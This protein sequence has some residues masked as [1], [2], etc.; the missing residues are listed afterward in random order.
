MATKKQKREALELKRAREA[1]ET[2]Q[3]GLQALERDRRRRAA[4]AR[5][6]QEEAKAE[7]DRLEEILRQ[8]ETRLR[9]ASMAGAGCGD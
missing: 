5:K 7:S 4:L 6:R 2:R 8:N 9:M 3:S 1:E